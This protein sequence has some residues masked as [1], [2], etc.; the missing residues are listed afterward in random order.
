M[1]RRLTPP[2]GEGGR[3]PV[4]AQEAAAPPVE[5]KKVDAAFWDKFKELQKMPP[6]E[7]ISG[8]GA[9][10][11]KYQ[12]PQ[13]DG[14]FKWDV[15]FHF[16]TH[17]EWLRAVIVQK[18][19]E[20]E[21]KVAL[22]HNERHTE[23]LRGRWDKGGKE[24][25]EKIISILEDALKGRVPSDEELGTADFSDPKSANN[26]TLYNLHQGAWQVGMLQLGSMLDICGMDDRVEQL[27]WLGSINDDEMKA[28]LW[29][30]HDEWEKKDLGAAN[31]M[32]TDEIKKWR[33][34]KGES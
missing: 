19:W 6:E 22:S 31:S 2:P 29:G 15:Y 1:K 32:L 20:F 27:Q 11:Q 4:P 30:W 28:V 5:K 17:P 3:P 26:P 33:E 23:R 14:A 16:F 25:R 10:L 24:S 7:R 34:G 8:I 21:R 18:Q 9:Y 13:G 12:K